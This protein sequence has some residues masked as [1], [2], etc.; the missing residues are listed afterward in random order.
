MTTRFGSFVPHLHLLLL[1]CLAFAQQL[2]D[3]LARNAEFFVIRG[4]QPVDLIALVVVLLMILP[5]PLLALSLIGS[6]IG[7]AAKTLT[8]RVLV[9]ALAT[10]IAL[11]V[12]KT[13]AIDTGAWL[14]AVAAGSALAW[15][16]HRFDPIKV[17]LT[18]LT[19]AILVVP[20]L[21]FSDA[22]VRRLMRGAST[23]LDLHSGGSE[24]PIFLLIFDELSFTSIL[25]AE[26]GVDAARYPNLA[27]FAARAT[28][29][30]NAATVSDVTPIALPAI[31]TGR[32]PH[33]GQLPSYEDHD[34]NLFT[35]FGGDYA[36]YAQEPITRLCPPEINLLAGEA[37]PFSARLAS[38]LSDLGIV[39]LHLVVPES[40]AE[41]LPQISNTWQGFHAPATSPSPG[42]AA[43]PRSAA[44]FFRAA[45]DAL[46]TRSRDQEFRSFVDAIV[47]ARRALYFGHFMLPH[48][49]WEYLPSGTRY[50]VQKGGIPGVR[51]ERWAE[52]RWLATQGLQ[53][54]LLQ[55]EFL[56]RLLGELF[57]RLEELDLFDRSLIV[58]V[59]DHGTSFRPGENRRLLSDVNAADIVPIPLFIKAPGQSEGMVVEA[60]VTTL[61]ILPTMLDLLSLEP[62]WP[63][64]GESG[65]AAHGEPR[66]IPFLG[67]HRGERIVDPSL[68]R[69]K[70]ATLDRKLSLVGPSSDP[71]ALFR[72][73]PHPQLVGQ[74]LGDQPRVRPGRATV[75][76]DEHQR[77]DHVDLRSPTRPALLTGTLDLPEP[78]APCC[79]LAVAIN[80]TIFATVPTYGARGGRHR[81]TALV[82]E[83]A[84]RAGNNRPEVL[85]IRDRHG[86]RVLERTR[87]RR[88]LTYALREGADHRVEAVL[89]DGV[90]YPVGKDLEGWI[91][92]TA[93][94]AE[95]VTVT[96]WAVDRARSGPV[97]EVVVFLDGVFIHAGSAL[98]DRE[99]VVKHYGDERFLESGFR[100]RLARE[101][102]PGLE[103]S[104]LRL[105]ALS[106]AGTAS[107]LGFL[108]HR[109]ERA[110]DGSEY[111]AVTDGR[112]LPL[113][114]GALAGK[115]DELGEDASGMLT[116]G[117]WAFDRK[118]RRPPKTIVAF[119]DGKHYTQFR[120]RLRR[121]TLARRLGF[122]KRLR[123][124]FRTRVP[125]GM[126]SHLTTGRMRLFAI[127]GTGV[128]SELRLAASD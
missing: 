118:L 3:L 18:Y 56:D 72:V 47:D 76:V 82:P 75:T 19:P 50:P 117:G 49:P 39:W 40:S 86:A 68:H 105:F 14:L 36:I 59:A 44:Q 22:D 6:R 94:D 23:S 28:W 108:W 12:L 63:L 17:F 10:L 45:L 107:E 101:K 91:S 73:G 58:L 26:R 120:T 95:A 102:L 112:K 60:P 115:I 99:S 106:A 15:L 126:K 87:Q 33:P 125:V 38:L 13:L 127:S 1:C 104:G 53:R 64:D 119:V 103:S 124:G 20:L 67:K 61:D 96:G 7:G 52:N 93:G 110:A 43:A 84:F 9:A 123:C 89:V 37:A 88:R 79:E 2:L 11:Q 71:F 113:T 98:L 74:R 57:D 34:R 90:A 69:E 24:A 48:V 77:Y 128:A 31:L 21:F 66:P 5:L 4:S 97:D 116:I 54:Y 70:Y 62:P 29:F 111:I 80:G 41:T 81:F 55:V 35:L 25:D 16:Y 8:H 121:P 46:H 122:P 78:V 42:D 92:S 83:V 100:F 27:A 51:K 65:L 32:L 85:V 109:L 30:K 114:P